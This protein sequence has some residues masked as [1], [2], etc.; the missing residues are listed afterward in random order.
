MNSIKRIMIYTLSVIFTTA[1]VYSQQE[2]A[3]QQETLLTNNNSHKVTII[4]SSEGIIVQTTNSIGELSDSIRIS[5]PSA[6]VITTRQ[7]DIQISENEDTF[8]LNKTKINRRQRWNIIFGGVCIGLSNPIGQGFG[9]GLEWSKSIEVGWFKCIGISY[10]MSRYTWL[11]LGIGLDWRNYK[12]TTSDKH[13]VVNPQR[14]LEW[15]AYPNGTIAKS[16]R[17]KIFSL[18]FPLMFTGR[19]PSTSL[20]IDVGPVFNLNTYGSVLTRYEDNLGNRYKDF[21]KDIDK[22]LFTVDL[23]GSVSLKKCIGIYARYSPMK[24][25]NG[26]SG[27]NFTPFSIGVTIGS[28]T[29]M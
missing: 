26:N 24:V 2:N 4:E 18:Q 11:S 27:I 22:R 23:F 1:T 29:F 12:I 17:L 10:E 14:Q 25:M 16:S 20:T 8:S 28:P 6:A 19:I 21:T 3:S 15:G 5:Y 9:G 7:N 13:L